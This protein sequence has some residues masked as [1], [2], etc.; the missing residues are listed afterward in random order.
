MLDIFD[1]ARKKLSKACKSD[2]DQGRLTSDPE[3]Y[4]RGKRRRRPAISQCTSSS[5]SED[6]PSEK[7]QRVLDFFPPPPSAV[8][9]VSYT[10][11]I[12]QTPSTV[13]TDMP[14]SALYNTPK[15]NENQCASFS[16]P[17]ENSNPSSFGATKNSTPKKQK[18]KKKG[19]VSVNNLTILIDLLAYF[20][21]KISF[22]FSY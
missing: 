22:L 8:T 20:I 1:N 19:K 14:T 2:I 4:G 7:V 17:K 13:L 16:T 21:L 11:S 6:E 10:K 12:Q 15:Q 9:P 5:S 18:K 3:S